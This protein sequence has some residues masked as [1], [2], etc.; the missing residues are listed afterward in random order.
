[1]IASHCAIGVAQH[2]FE[3]KDIPIDEQGVKK[4][5]MHIERNVWIG[6][7]VTI[8]SGVTIGEGS[9]IGAGALVNK[10]IPPFS[11]AVGIPARV[12]RSR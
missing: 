11:V 10:D 5:D 3:K 6:A 12:I 9:V 8:F 1:M 2:H 7:H 4:L